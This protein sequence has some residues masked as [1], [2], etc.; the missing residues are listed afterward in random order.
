MTDAGPVARAAE[1]AALG[2]QPTLTPVDVERL[3]RGLD[4]DDDARVRAAALGA[5]ARAA[6]DDAVDPWERAST[7]DAAAVRRRAAEL[8]PV[9]G[10]RLAVA[11]VL[12]LLDDPDVTVV[13][14]A[15]WAAGELGARAV[16]AGAVATLARVARDHRDAFGAR[17][18]GRRPWRAR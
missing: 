9:L 5:L 3:Q 6:P 8:A 11:P 4:H 7:D 2:H 14:A 17:S 10:T 16:A 18:R 12:A 1:L 15:A 13:E